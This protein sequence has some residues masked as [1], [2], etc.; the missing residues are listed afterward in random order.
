VKLI[1]FCVKYPVTVWVGVVLALLFGGLG[2]MRLPLQMIPTVD[3]PEITVETEY[4]GAAALE[5]EREITRRQEE[6]LN[7]VENL[8]EMTSTSIEGKSTI[9]LKFDWGT[10]KDIARLGVSEKL[11]LVTEVPEDA[12]EP[13]IRAVNTDEETPIAWILVEGDRPLNEIWEEVIDVVSPRL[14]RVGGV[15]AVWRFGGQDR[16]VHV[17]LD[18]R[19]MAARGLT[20]ADVRDAIVNENRTTKGGQISEGKRRTV[21]RTVGEFT[22]IRRLGDIVLRPAGAGPSVVYLRD[23]AR[24][25][26]GHRDRDFAVRTNGVPAIGLGVLRRSGANTIATMA[27]IQAEVAY[28]NTVVYQGKGIRLTQVYDETTYIH[29]SLAQVTDNVY[30]GVA[31]TVVVLL[32][33]LRSVGPTVVNALAIPISLMATFMVL[34]MLGRTLNI[35]LLAGLAFAAGV[36]VDNAT[37][38]LENIVRHRELGK[39]P[40]RAAV[41]GA[42]EVWGA[43][44]AA[45]L[46]TVAVFIPIFFVQQEA[47]QLFRDLALAVVIS[48]LLSL[49][50]SVT[51]VPMLAARLTA[52]ASTTARF[53]RLTGVLDRIGGGF[54]GAVVAFLDWL[55]RGVWRRLATAA[56]IVIA[57]VAVSYVVMPPMD[58]LPQGNRNLFFVLVRTPP[59]YSTEQ[60]EDILRVLEQRY[61][62]LPEIDRYFSV[63]RVEEPL[64]GVLAKP[65]YS[66]LPAMRALLATLRQQS[67]GVP[68]T[69]A[70]FATQSPLF[71]TRGAF[72]GGTNIQVDVRGKDLGVIQEVA[73]RLEG[74]LRRFRGANFVNSSFEWGNPELQVS[75]DRERAAGLGLSAREVGYIVETAVG[76]TLAGTFKEGGKEID[77]KLLANERG[78]SRTQD[79][80]RTVFFTRAG[81]PLRLAEIADVSAAA[82][83]TKVQHVDQDRAISITMNVTEQMALEEAVTAVETEIIGPAR[84]ALPL[85]YTITVAGHARD[86][87]EAFNALK[88]SYL[89]AQI[90]IYLLL[91]SLFESWLIPFYIMFSVPLAVTGGVLAVR[92]AHALEPAVKMDTVTMLGFIILSG[93]VVSNAIL[94]VHQALNNM[95]A[96]QEP[97]EALVSSVATRI[98]PIFITT[99]TT[100]VGVLPLVVS[101]GSGSELYRGLGSA[102]LGGLA[103]STLV[104]LLLVPVVYS[105]GLDAQRALRARRPRWRRALGPTPAPARAKAAA[106]DPEASGR[107]DPTG[108]S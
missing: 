39:P 16:E 94:I 10:N 91:A 103:L 7:S 41:E 14:E 4:P 32:L 68:G 72:F 82:G 95:R 5:V 58:Y 50:V 64:M 23:V 20:T 38:V 69:V 90:V 71:R 37:V 13:Q 18:Q 102:V 35:I 73:E 87:T 83:P 79:V 74:Q 6:K 76:G 27:G 99:L 75:I 106:L 101:S 43:I 80:H 34:Y 55:R 8:R 48:T 25:R 24:V 22:D 51:V 97:Q 70:V 77:I 61:A 96:G 9:V 100:V 60:K 62:R 15:G 1:E 45:T 28:L 66:A 30:W 105:L 85:G 36:V 89:L 52:G 88:W 93:I 31:L 108:G 65:E 86:L 104:T 26:F 53:P 49:A 21:V 92:W 11:D 84:L 19:A 56:A 54:V 42:S 81:V 46:T 63:V 33:T 12:K 47:G 67:Q 29:E 44:L 40:M 3:V 78:S 98:R 57:S 59:G 2:L 17:I 107:A